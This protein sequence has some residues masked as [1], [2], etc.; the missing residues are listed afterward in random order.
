MELTR[1][2]WAFTDRSLRATDEPDVADEFE[3]T[4]EAGRETGRETGRDG[5]GVVDIAGFRNVEVL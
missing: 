1:S 3:G 4:R 2:I 5:T